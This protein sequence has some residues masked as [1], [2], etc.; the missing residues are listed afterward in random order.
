VISSHCRTA[1]SNR[2]SSTPNRRRPRRPRGACGSSSTGISWRVRAELRVTQRHEGAATGRPLA[3]APRTAYVWECDPT[4][5]SARLRNGR[6]AHGRGRAVRRADRRGRRAGALH[7]PDLDWARRRVA[8]ALLRGRTQR[9]PGTSSGGAASR[10]SLQS[11]AQIA[12]RSRSHH[13][14]LIFERRTSA[15]VRS[16]AARRTRRGRAAS[17]GRRLRRRG[18]PPSRRRGGRGCGARA[19]RGCGRAPLR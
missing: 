7:R 3:A 2:P 5:S 10:S 19:P 12:Q 18:R 9:G 17:P 4:L 14:P 16:G 11:S 8:F 6:R 13:S 15:T 1:S